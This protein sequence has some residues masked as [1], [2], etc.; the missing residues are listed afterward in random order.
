MLMKLPPQKGTHDKFIHSSTALK[1]VSVPQII[2][3]NP[4]KGWL[5]VED[6]GDDTLNCICTQ[7]PS[8]L[9]RY[10]KLV[11]DTLIKLQRINPPQ[12]ISMFDIE[13]LNFELDLFVEWYLRQ[14][15]QAN[16][17]TQF[18]KEWDELKLRILNDIISQ[19]YVLTHRDYHS[20]NILIYND[21]IGV[22][23]HQDILYGPVTYDIC[24][25]LR[26]IYMTLT[27]E[28]ESE[29]LK[30]YYDKAVEHGLVVTNYLSFKNEY[31][32]TSL[33]RHIKILGL[34][35]RLAIRDSKTQYLKYL[36]K[37]QDYVFNEI[38]QN[39]NYKLILGFIK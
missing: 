18:I 39:D 6:F 19:K 31:L 30:Y 37:T 38:S 35:C 11:I 34:F 22:I 25:L 36:S 12:V 20:R 13:T 10:Y 17:S 4:Q 1:S 8:M 29:L 3:H 26:D 5:L 2:A 28:E 15:K 33:Q 24:S 21:R 27:P 14:Y 9:N 23:D 7:S 32:V 16:I